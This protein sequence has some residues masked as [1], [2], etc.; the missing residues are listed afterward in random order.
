MSQE[1]STEIELKPFPSETRTKLIAIGAI[2]AAVYAISV[3]VPISSFIGAGSILSLAITIAPLFGILLGPRYGFVFGL[4][5]GVLATIVSSQFG[6]LYLAVPTIIFGPAISGFLT[7][8]S[9][10]RTTKIGNISLP[11]PLLTSVYLLIIIVLYL[12][13]HYSAW[14]FILPYGLAAL[15][16]LALQFYQTQLEDISIA[17]FSVSILP[18]ALIG[19]MTDFS[20]M[21]MG[22]V[23]I[24][25]L[26][27]DLFGFVIFP[28][29]LIERFLAV[30]VSTLL[31]SLVIATFGA[32]LGFQ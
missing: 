18:F 15:T 27:A 30:I 5:G 24:L 10:K 28:V 32:D 4:I 2:I 3:I 17:R 14:W 13:P 11:G 25:G 12:I 19:T 21:T 29:M 9:M 6:G 8:L 31:A 1:E 23:Y 20:M 16:A 22:A 7:G 26:H